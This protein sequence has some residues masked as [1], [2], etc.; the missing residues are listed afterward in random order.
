MARPTTGRPGASSGVRSA[1]WTR[2]ASLRRPA[3]SGAGRRRRWA[4]SAGRAGLRCRT[5]AA[6]AAVATGRLTRRGAAARAAPPANA[7]GGDQDSAWWAAGHGQMGTPRGGRGGWHARRTARLV[8]HVAQPGV[9]VCVFWH[10]TG[11]TVGR[12]NED[13][14]GWMPC[15]PRARRAVVV[16]S[17]P[18]RSAG[19]QLLPGLDACG[20]QTTVP[21]CQRRF[22]SMSERCSPCREAA[23][24][25]THGTWH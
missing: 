14:W 22:T 23:R 20:P 15:R 11:S 3:A 2:R 18:R 10:V 9:C 19:R 8:L 4:W 1:S 21:C 6:A 7:E 25:H 5:L 17:P 16:A 13:C 24:S 12:W